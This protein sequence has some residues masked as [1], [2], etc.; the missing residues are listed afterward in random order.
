M[1]DVRANEDAQ[2]LSRYKDFIQRYTRQARGG[3]LYSE[4]LRRHAR[5]GQHWLQVDLD[6]LRV[7]TTRPSPMTSCV[8]Q[9][10]I[11]VL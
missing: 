7:C 11:S 2:A 9:P 8:L 1:S 3:F 6:D 10:H 4:Q 5:L